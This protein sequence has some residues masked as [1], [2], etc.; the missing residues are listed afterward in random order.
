MRTLRFARPLGR[1]TAQRGVVLFI[2]LIVLVAM[3]LAAIA[4][5][6][7][8]DTNT[9][10]AGN[11]AFK[12][13]ALNSTDQGVEA[14]YRWLVTNAGTVTLNNT[15]LTKG[16]VSARPASEPDWTDPAQWTAAQG[17][18]CINGC[19]ADANGNTVY[20]VIH[21]MCTQENTTYNGTGATGK[22]NQCATLTPTGT[23]ATGNS[24]NAGSF[25]FQTNP[26][27]YYRITARVVGPRNATSVVQAMIA[28]S[29]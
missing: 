24:N 3:T 2:A 5:M 17:V 27:L 28:L 11:I 10:I 9:V 25:N 16:F 6:R 7:S 15:D 23:A 4:L 8:V 21:R 12:S 14:A 20:Y 22:P 13:A 1:R 29:N 26:Q 19:V 18:L